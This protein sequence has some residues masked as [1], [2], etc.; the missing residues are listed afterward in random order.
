MTAP[1]VIEADA[2]LA[3]EDPPCQEFTVTW[4]LQLDAANPIRAARLARSCQTD[5]HA[6]STHFVVSGPDGAVTQV[7][8]LVDDDAGDFCWYDHEVAAAAREGWGVFSVCIDGRRFLD[9]QRDDEMGVL[10]SDAEAVRLVLENYEV[11]LL[12]RRA[13]CLVAASFRDLSPSFWAS[14]SEPQK[15]ELIREAFSEII[16]TE[17]FH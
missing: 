16:N 9:L 5:L 11:S 17:F 1:S 15:K 12:H 13:A 2:A 14:L 10:D 4:T 3:S 6:L 8:T 7:D